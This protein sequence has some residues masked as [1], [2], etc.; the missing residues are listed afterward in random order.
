[1]FERAG[2]NTLYCRVAKILFSLIID[3]NECLEFS[4]CHN[5]GTCINQAGGYVCQCPPGWTG[6]D[7]KVGEL[8]PF[9]P[10]QNTSTV[11]IFKKQ[12]NY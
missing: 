5:G 9:F 7:C 3:L 4:P 12:K 1:M 6:K 11:F 8:S 10:I 2:G